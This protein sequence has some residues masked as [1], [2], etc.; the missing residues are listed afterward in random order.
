MTSMS[1]YQERPDMPGKVPLGILILLVVAFMLFSPYSN[2]G[3][4]L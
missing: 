1:N 3:Q 2:C 4:N